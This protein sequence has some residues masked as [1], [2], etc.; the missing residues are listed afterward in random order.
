M[1]VIVVFMLILTYSIEFYCIP[2]VPSSQPPTGAATGFIGS[3]VAGRM[4]INILNIVFVHVIFTT[5]P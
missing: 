2:D 1:V 4:K 3:V 5:E